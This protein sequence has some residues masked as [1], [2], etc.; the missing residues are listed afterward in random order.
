M[1][2]VHKL[3][4]NDIIKTSQIIFTN[5]ENS[6]RTRCLKL[7]LKILVTISFGWLRFQMLIKE[8]DQFKV[9]TLKD[10]S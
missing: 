7:A 3:V 1:D 4:D 9:L 10:I 5:R 2:N 8:L 6:Y